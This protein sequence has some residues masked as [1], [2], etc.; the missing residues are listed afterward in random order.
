LL[1]PAEVPSGVWD[2]AA[3]REARRSFKKLLDRTLEAFPVDLVHMHGLDFHDYLPDRGLPVVVT[4]HLPISWYA[5]GALCGVGANVSLVSV[6]ESQARMAARGI[7]IRRV[8]PNGID[9]RGF[10]PTERKSNYAVALS[11][12]CP[13]KG[14]HL[15][16]D[17]AE[18]AGIELIIAGRVFEYPEHRAYFD[19]MVRPRLNARIRFIGRVGGAGK[20]ALLAGARCLLISSLAPETSSLA[21]M[22]AM[23][24]G[25]PVV[26]FRS[27]AL[28]EIVSSGRTGFLVDDVEEMAEAIRR[29]DGIDPG[30]CRSEAE[31]RF[32]SD[33]MFTNYLELYRA[34]TH[35]APVYE[36]EAR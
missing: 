9:L 34:V 30:V 32:S 27:G 6:S 23:A 29:A 35:G 17:A 33:C 26:A 16:A 11:R 3:K 13:E 12:V 2:E 8:I 1:I 25:T 36:R 24:S 31:R 10:H 21:A 18:L 19:S 22:E 14:T 15:A 4:L 5:A 20:A 28:S 7:R